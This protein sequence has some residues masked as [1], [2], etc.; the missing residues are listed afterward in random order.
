MALTM[1]IAIGKGVFE[2]PCRK[3]AGI[4]SVLELELGFIEDCG[5]LLLC[6]N[7]SALNL[8]TLL[9]YNERIYL[10]E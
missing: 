6:S 1:A 7:C 8:L 9:L 4:L 5:M 3:T 2:H 10:C